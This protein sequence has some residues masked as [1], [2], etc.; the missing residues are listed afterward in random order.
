MAKHMLADGS[1]RMVTDD[2]LAER[3]KQKQDTVQ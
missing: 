2:E 1:G 3:E